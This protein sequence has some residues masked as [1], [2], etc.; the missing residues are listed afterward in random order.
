[1]STVRFSGSL[2]RIT[3]GLEVSRYYE[4]P[5]GNNQI[6]YGLDCRRVTPLVGN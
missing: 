6:T 4:S 1:M 3:G 2:D 5:D